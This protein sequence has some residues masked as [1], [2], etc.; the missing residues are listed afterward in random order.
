MDYLREIK[1]IIK[2]FCENVPAEGFEINYLES[3]KELYEL[4]GEALA[5]LENEEESKLE[6]I[7][8]KAKRL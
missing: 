1:K 3:A 4:Y 6:E 2:E 5:K 8:E 7:Y